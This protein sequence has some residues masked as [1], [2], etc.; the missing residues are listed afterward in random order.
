MAEI[1]VQKFQNWT[2]S[3]R[4][5]RKK[6]L[7]VVIRDLQ[8]WN[9]AVASVN[10]SPAGKNF[11]RERTEVLFVL[12]LFFLKHTSIYYRFW[13]FFLFVCLFF[14]FCHYCAFRTSVKIRIHSAKLLQLCLT[15][16]T[17]RTVVCQA[18]LSMRFSRQEY[19]SGLPLPPPGDFPTQEL[20]LC[21][22]WLLHCRRI[23]HPW[24]PPGN[25]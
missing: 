3:A 18:A 8:R 17:P 11:P 25:T 2:H 24:A 4:V 20:N 23:F 19:W 9:E 7:R 5:G 6:G 13:R 22:L 1:R 16:A 12:L 14:T 10:L 15:L 21:L